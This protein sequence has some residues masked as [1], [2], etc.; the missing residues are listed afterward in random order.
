MAPYCLV[1][2]TLKKIQNA[3]GRINEY[4]LA[5]KE[6]LLKWNKQKNENSYKMK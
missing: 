1:N 6:I 4:I 2:H 3:I 5:C